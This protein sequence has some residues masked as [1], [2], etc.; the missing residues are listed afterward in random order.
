[1]KVITAIGIP[2]INER[3][4]KID[5]Y[6]VIG[7]DIQ[8][9]EGILELLE[10]REDIEIVFVSNNLP[11]DMSFNTLINKII[12]IK[13]DIEIIVFLKE[14]NE[15]IEIF[16]NS[17]KIYKIYYLDN[18]EMFFANFNNSMSNADISKNIEDFKKIIL[19]EKNNYTL[20]SDEKN[21]QIKTKPIEIMKMLRKTKENKIIEVENYKKVDCGKVIS[22][23]GV[24]GCGKSITA[25]ILSKYL[26]TKNKV[27]LIDFD[28]LNSSINTILGISKTPETQSISNV[29]N[30]IIEYEENFYVLTS[31]DKIARNYDEK[32]Y[33]WAVEIFEKLKYEFDYI[34][35]DT[36]TD[37][38]TNK[39]SS[40]FAYSCEI[41]YLIEP[42]LSEVKKS[43]LYL[44]KILKDFEI[45]ESRINIIFNKSNKNKISEK[46]LKEIYSEVNIIGEI[47]YSEK[48]NL[49][50]NKN[51]Y[52]EMN[53]YENIFE[54]LLEME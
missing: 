19:E 36:E 53:I 3:L 44:E 8:Y 13:N 48:Y 32:N 38:K 50:I 14:K 34:I 30:S 1:M 47:E 16:L 52:K 35:V 41:I 9:Q 54:K 12:N 18:Y 22:I 4:K 7:K 45:E 6:E 24:H 5:D 39:N 2:E 40:I 49:I 17:K 23:S 27:L 31:I 10:E 46:V 15:S 20:N 42:N 25:I 37:E 43:N 21:K 28:I 33:Y 51:I 29:H 26:S 11:E